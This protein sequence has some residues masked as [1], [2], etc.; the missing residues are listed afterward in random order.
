MK[1]VLIKSLQ[2]DIQISHKGDPTFN[3]KFG[4]NPVSVPENIAFFILSKSSK[5]F[6]VIDDKPKRKSRIK[7]ED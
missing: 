3:I 5:E 1:T 2:P 4:K 7:E 6:V